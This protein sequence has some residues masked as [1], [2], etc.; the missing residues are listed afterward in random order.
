[1]RIDQ[2]ESARRFQRSNRRDDD[3]EP[4]PTD[5]RHSAAISDRPSAFNNSPRRFSHKP[6]RDFA[7]LRLT[8]D[9][10][11]ALARPTGFDDF[12]EAAGPRRHGAD[13]VGQHGRLVER[14]GNQQHGR[15]GAPPQPQHLVS[16]QKA[17]LGVERAERLV[18][19]NETRL[20]HQ[21]PGNAD[22]LAHAT[23]KLRRI[24]ASEILEPHEGDRVFDPAADFGG[25][26][27]VLP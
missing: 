20:Q 13:T 8:H 9:G 25:S 1:M 7:E 18:E 22:A 19:Q 16:H 5:A 15:A 3:D 14:V 6:S 11:V 26:R 4:D 24:G 2:T 12:H 27:P 10:A 21:R 23:G 17:R